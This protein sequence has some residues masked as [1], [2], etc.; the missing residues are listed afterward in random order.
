[1]LHAEKIT[2]LCWPLSN[3]QV[4]EKVKDEIESL[5][6]EIINQKV[7]RYGQVFTM[8]PSPRH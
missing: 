5:I 7:G 3:V 4:D 8:E 6:L 2:P 1:M